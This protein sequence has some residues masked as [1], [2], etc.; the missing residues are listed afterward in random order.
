MTTHS[1]ENPSLPAVVLRALAL[2][3]GRLKAGWWGLVPLLVFQAAVESAAAVVV[4]LVL[5]GPGGGAPFSL[6]GVPGPL[7]LAALLLLKNALV[8]AT[9][10]AEAF[11][12]AE[13]MRSAFERLLRGFVAAPLA[14]RNLQHAADL[15]YTAGPA[16]DE[17]FRKT[18]VPAANLATEA[19]VVSAITAVLVVR[20]P[21]AGFLAAG[22]LGVALIATIRAT[23]RAVT[24][25][26]RDHETLSVR[27]RRDLGDLLGGIADLQALGREEPVVRTIMGRHEAF[28]RAHRRLAGAAAR[29]RPLV[30]LVFVAGLFAAVLAAPA[31]AA[32][33]AIPLLGLFAYAGFRIL[34][35]ANRTLYH[36]QEMRSGRP[37]VLRL[38][39][40][41]ARFPAPAGGPAPDPAPF[42]DRIV[43]DSVTVRPVGAPAPSL[44]EVSLVVRQGEM[45]G[46]AGATGAG[47]ST[48]LTVL[49]GLN[50]PD[51]GTVRFDGVAAGSPGFSRR[52]TGYVPQAPFVADD[53]LLRNVAFGL[54]DGEIDE[55]RAR[56][57]LEAARLLEFAI[58]L[59]DGLASRAG[60]NGALL[61]GG[62]R[63]RLAVARAL[64]ADPEILLLDEAT[65]ALDPATEG[66][67]V[68]A[69][70][71]L[72]PRKTVVLVSH[73]P[74]ALR[75]VDRV[76]FLEG[77]RVAGD[78]SF[79]ELVAASE[80]FRTLV[81]RGGPPAA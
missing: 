5:A 6:G 54:S 65:S 12:L 40:D 25:A 41:L 7:L 58:R 77:G 53:T 57:A 34:P 9:T 1:R 70:R 80:A 66:E 51:S 35:A 36:V 28:A 11:L 52:R 14:S 22:L 13:S 78:A 47:K 48:L 81:G 39:N 74:D 42:R 10:Q 71:A 76:V 23:E 37:A 55:A 50:A 8:V 27:L 73:R 68:A 26:S 60:E 17:A 24:A 46:V 30:E 79:D 45:V 59:P 61:S 67:V 3:P 62:E 33:S 72:V 69:L 19:A 21:L 32:P 29:S 2:L 49:A 16:V 63:Q 15:S 31:G 20:A 75:A 4:Y 44:V 56:A 38:E 64:Y 43:L 18:L